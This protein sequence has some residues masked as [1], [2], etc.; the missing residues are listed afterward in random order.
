VTQLLIHGAPKGERRRIVVDGGAWW[1]VDPGRAE[2]VPLELLF[3]PCGWKVG[4]LCKAL[5]MERRTFARVM[6]RSL[7]ITGKKWLCQLRVVAACHLLRGGKITSVA[8]RLGFRDDSDFSFEF[9]RQMG[10]SPSAF[11][12]SE[13][14]RSFR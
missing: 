1:F 7:G 6:E 10:V 11:V 9:R 2:K 8:S 5:G 14:S 4:R 3:G 12:K 13:R